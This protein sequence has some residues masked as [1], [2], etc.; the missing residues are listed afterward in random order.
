MANTPKEKRVISKIASDVSKIRTA[1]RLTPK[2]IIC[3][4]VLL[5]LVFIA[6]ALYKNGGSFT[7]AITNPD[8][9]YGLSLCESDDF[10]SPTS[11]LK[12][13]IA[14]KITNI[15]GE[16]DLPADLDNI[17]GKH[18]GLNYVAYTF[19]CKNTGSKPCT[20]QYELYFESTTKGIE[21]AIRI[22]I[23]E[24]GTPTT[25]ART[26]SDGT[27]PEKGT[28]EFLTETIVTKQQRENFE[29]NNIKKFTVVIWIEGWDEDCTDDIIGGVLKL[30]MKLSAIPID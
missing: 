14:E 20:L 30:N 12:A 29:V 2:I 25:F 3:L 22:R 8:K 19:Y 26:R 15:D 16:T 1:Q 13:D 9:S 23:Y 10:F 11:V 24:D 27:G 21:K 17:N 4:V 6:A 7:V 5:A 28:K 18:N